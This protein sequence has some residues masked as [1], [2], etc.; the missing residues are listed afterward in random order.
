MWLHVVAPRELTCC[1]SLGLDSWAPLA[2]VYIQL[3]P[4]LFPPNIWTTEAAPDHDH[5]LQRMPSAAV[6]PLG[7]RQAQQVYDLLVNG[8]QVDWHLC[9]EHT[10]LKCLHYKVLEY[11]VSPGHGLTVSLPDPTRAQRK[12]LIM[13]TPRNN[14]GEVRDSRILIRLT[15]KL[16][17]PTP[18]LV[19]TKRYIKKNYTMC[20][21]VNHQ[22]H[23]K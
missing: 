17:H 18:F 20:S 1:F 8:S 6:C 11:Y 7:D 12:Q 10:L 5:H 15:A 4:D 3:R 22:F 14:G 21:Q 16:G 13:I 23:S 2:A 19:H 9:M